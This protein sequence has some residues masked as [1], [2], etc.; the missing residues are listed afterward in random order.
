MI[1]SAGLSPAWQQIL[2]FDALA[3]GEINR[4]T[5]AR[6]C[7]S[8]KVLN[9]GRAVRSLGADGHTVC[10]V[11]GL[12]GRAIRDEFAADRIPAT[13][14]ETA[15]PTRVCTT[16][17]DRS[18][19]PSGRVTELVE[20]ARAI[21]AEELAEFTRA[22]QACVVSADLL[23]LSGSLPLLSCGDRPADLYRGLLLDGPPAILDVRGPELTVALSGRPKLVKPNRAELSATVGHP[24]PDEESVVAAMKTLNSQGAEWVLVTNGPRDMVLTQEDAA[25]RLTPPQ[26]EIVNP[27]GC[28]DCLAAGIAVALQEGEAM[29]DAVRFGVAAAADNLGQLLPAR[30]RLDVV[31]RTTQDVNVVRI[32]S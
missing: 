18:V 11:G 29:V 27:I 13:W 9:V 1:L 22:Y 24:L 16:L 30:L 5:D 15:S 8:G 23:V 20:N 3:A 14:I 28:G 17:I 31:H 2:T 19:A 6:W 25:W 26:R 10:P 12:P 7:A 4:A 32:S 21:T